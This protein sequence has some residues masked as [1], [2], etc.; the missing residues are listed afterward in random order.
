MHGTLLESKGK[1]NKISVLKTDSLGIVM[2]SMQHIFPIAP[3]PVLTLQL[4]HQPKQL[5]VMPL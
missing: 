2:T 3:N 4:E 5:A 1:C